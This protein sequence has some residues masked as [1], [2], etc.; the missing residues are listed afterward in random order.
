MKRT[1]LECL[2]VYTSIELTAGIS[3]IVVL[4]NFF[5]ISDNGYVILRNAHLA[6]QLFYFLHAFHGQLNVVGGVTT[7]VG[8]TFNQDGFSL[9][10]I[11]HRD[12][13]WFHVD[14][15]EFILVECKVKRSQLN[16][17]VVFLVL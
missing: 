11:F 9:Q 6:H 2:K 3:R 16:R 1:A 17:L 7:A 12:E 5:A 15:R 8:V 13:E 10:R 4:R 14:D